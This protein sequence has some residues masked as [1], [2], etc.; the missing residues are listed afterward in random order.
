MFSINRR[1][2]ITTCVSALLATATM[3]RQ[4][5][6][7]PTGEAVPSRAS[8]PVVA[9]EAIA[10][11]ALAPAMQQSPSP[12]VAPPA[13]SLPAVPFARTQPANPS[14]NPP[15]ATSGQATPSASPRVPDYV[16]E[17]GFKGR[18]FEIRHREPDAIAMA[19]RPLASGFKG[20]TMSPNREFKILTVRD[21][22]EN[23]AAIEE[24]LKRLDVPELPGSELE[25]LVHILIATAGSAPLGDYP[26]DLA[27]VVKQL[28]GTLK[29]K[30]YGLLAS[31][32]VRGREGATPITSSGIA[33]SKLLEITT[34]E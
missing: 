24:A 8:T 21:F 30:N 25:F 9:P 23:I 20:A 4:S 17:K 28:Q 16:E 2:V 3:A 14:Q 32:I 12:V 7:R 22:P 26:A 11:P 6:Q 10:A 1:V 5:P 27:P 19:V 33:E 15:R 18:V 13:H 34:P 29:Y 31:A